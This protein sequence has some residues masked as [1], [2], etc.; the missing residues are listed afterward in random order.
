MSKKK[1][2][3]GGA[4]EGAGRKPANPEGLTM[5]VVATIP[6]TLVESLE[7]V[8]KAQGGIGQG[9]SLRRYG[10]LSLAGSAERREGK[11]TLQA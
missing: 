6:R 8:A 11:S 9:P 3:R 7:A 4:R 10:P 5:V 1:S 2:G